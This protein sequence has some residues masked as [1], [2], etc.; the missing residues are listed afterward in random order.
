MQHKVKIC[1]VCEDISH[2]GEE[3]CISFL[4]KTRLEKLQT[5]IEWVIKI[6]LLIGALFFSYDVFCNWNK[7]D[8]NFKDTKTNETI[9][10]PTIVICFEPNVKITELE[11]YNISL[12]EF[13]NYEIKDNV[14]N[15][16]FKKI[17]TTNKLINRNKWPDFYENISYRIGRDFNI[18]IKFNSKETWDSPYNIT[19]NDPNYLSDKINFKEIYTLWH[20]ICNQIVPKVEKCEPVL[21]NY[22]R[23]NFNDSIVNKNEDLPNIKVFFTSEN[24]SYGI[25]TSKWSEGKKLSV[26]IDPKRKLYTTID[27]AKNR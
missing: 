25:I 9:D 19:I 14:M 17:N 8:T 13:L 2:Y 6:C 26:D 5:A 20:G 3:S 15:H 21:H 4:K 10:H 24:N 18:S 27:L 7:E 1:G 11:K 22:I 16:Y 12:Q 23:V